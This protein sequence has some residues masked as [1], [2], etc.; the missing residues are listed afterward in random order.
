MLSYYYVRLLLFFLVNILYLFI[1]WQYVIDKLNLD[2][3]VDSIIIM[4]VELRLFWQYIY[5]YLYLWVI[6]IYVS[7]WSD[8][9]WNLNFKKKFDNRT[10]K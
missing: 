1:Y 9:H 7:Y 8:L 2:F 4:L 6:Y 3:E 5:I 10:I